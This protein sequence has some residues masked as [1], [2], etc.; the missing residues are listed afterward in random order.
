MIMNKQ[1]GYLIVD[2]RILPD[3]CEKVVEARAL[4]RSGKA[5][6]ISEAV[7]AVKISRSTYYKY[8]DYVFSPSETSMEQKAVISLMLKHI[9]GSLSEVLQ[10]LSSKGANILTISQNFPIHGE[11]N[12]VV[13][14]ELTHVAISIDELIQT[15]QTLKSVSSARLISID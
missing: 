12:V 2:K 10:F 5:K 13:S 8:K 3:C 11:A 4:L 7:K 14:L 9:Q 15:I 6:D 1:S